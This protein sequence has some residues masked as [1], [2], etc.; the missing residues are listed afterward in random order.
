MLNR[1]LRGHVRNFL[2]GCTLSECRAY[3]AQ[4]VCDGT[5]GFVEEF[6]RELEA[7]LDGPVSGNDYNLPHTD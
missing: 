7:E 3:R 1:R 5:E 2:V 4:M 6:I